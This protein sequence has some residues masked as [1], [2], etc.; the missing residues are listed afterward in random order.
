MVNFNFIIL[1]C[2][3]I[4]TLLF[5]IDV[6]IK[7]PFLCKKG[8]PLHY[9]HH[10]GIMYLM[11]GWL[12]YFTDKTVFIIWFVLLL[13]TFAGWKVFDGCLITHATSDICN[14][15]RK[16]ITVKDIA[17]QRNPISISLLE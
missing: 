9:I 5:I 13:S 6:G 7:Q 10:V 15:P 16:G 2:V 17:R 1:Y 3:I 12:S 14:L 8:W 4:G 11:L